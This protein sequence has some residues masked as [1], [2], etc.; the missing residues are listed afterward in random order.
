[1]DII[2]QPFFS[3]GI[4]QYMN[5]SRVTGTLE[6]N[7]KVI[8]DKIKV[9]KD[10]SVKAHLCSMLKVGQFLLTNGL[11]VKTQDVANLFG[12]AEL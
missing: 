4:I 5:R 10:T 12:E 3:E 2:Q 7:M 11:Y 1:M 6:E 8:E 9:A